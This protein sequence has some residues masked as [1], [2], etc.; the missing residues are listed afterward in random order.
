M[1]IIG[2]TSL[3]TK[4]D[5]N[6][7][8]DEFDHEI[9][10]TL[11]ENKHNVLISGCSHK[12]IENIIDNI[13][14]ATSTKFTEVIGGFHLNHYNPENNIETEYLKELGEYLIDSR[15]TKY[16]SCHCTGDV[17]FKELNKEMHDKLERI[18]TG[19]VI[20]IK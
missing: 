9:Y 3:Y 7:V 16:Y 13:E 20:E 12:G 1:L 2:D 17:A 6:R 15:N 19:S 14:A 18:K 8:L 4:K 5:G 10:L 11:K